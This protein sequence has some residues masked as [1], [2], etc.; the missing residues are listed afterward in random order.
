MQR[1]A[2]KSMPEIGFKATSIFFDGCSRSHWTFLHLLRKL[3]S[4][5][6][7]IRRNLSTPTLLSLY[8]TSSRILAG[9]ESLCFA[10]QSRRLTG[11]K[12]P[13]T[14]SA[15][16]GWALRARGT[17]SI[18][19]ARCFDMSLVAGVD[20]TKEIFLAERV[21]LF[22]YKAKMEGIVLSPRCCTRCWYLGCRSSR[23]YQCP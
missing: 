16:P 6:T 18:H 19:R 8:L 15:K 3:L 2:T 21:K 22:N 4:T 7:W 20:N 12:S 5:P 9:L 13:S 10:R 17:S 23:S 14:C 11:A 1:C